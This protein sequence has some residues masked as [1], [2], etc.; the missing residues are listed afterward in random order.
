MNF[1][2]ATAQ[3]IIF[4]PG[5]IASLPEVT[6]GCGKKP[7]VV[8]G[9]GVARAQATEEAV[10]QAGFMPFVIRIP[11]EPTVDL[12]A[13]ATGAARSAGCDFVIAM[14][15]GSVI[16]A[17]KAISA[18]L[19][20]PGDLFRYLE[21]IG[22]GRPL[23]NTPLPCIAIPTT[24][25]TGA[26]VTKNAVL[27]SPPHR[28]KV[29][30]RHPHLMPRAAIVDPLLTLSLPPAQTA[31]TGMD[32]I[33]QLIEPFLSKSAN[34]MT[35]ALVREA[36]PRAFRALPA[37]CKNGETPEARKEM[38]FA[39]LCGGMALANAKLGAVHG[40][41]GP[42]GGMLPEAPHGAIC[43]NLLAP[44]L[45]LNLQI[46][47][48]LEAKHPLLEK[49]CE[50]GRMLSGNTQATPEF[51]VEAIKGL[52]ASLPIPTLSDLGLCRN[53]LPE[54]VAK[55]ASSSSMKGNPVDIP[56]NR[57]SEM[58]ESLLT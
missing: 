13:T 21:V 14:G 23:E 20:N 10:R 8:T 46:V 57:L 29:S 52:R 45:A 5:C 49:F 38:S 17:G 47:R 25:G 24:A 50:L 3:K 31:A 19:T 7:C 56:A 9:Y 41:A 35:D 40:L 11:G 15:G 34:P 1:E 2:F 54:L 28:V 33:S 22:E 42:M 32:A 18:F 39:A 36:L 37:A 48:K 16:D 27:G 30:V 44:V 55:S 6:V 26:E 53:L 43:A 58:L 51:A 12:V 4:G